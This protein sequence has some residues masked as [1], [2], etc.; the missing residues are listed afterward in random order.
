MNDMTYEMKIL[1]KEAS[2]AL[3]W[4]DMLW[5]D[6]ESVNVTIETREGKQTMKGFPHYDYQSSSDLYHE[7][8]R[9]KE[10]IDR[11]VNKTA[12]QIEEELKQFIGSEQWFPFQ[13]GLELTEGVKYVVDECNAA[14]FVDIIGKSQEKL[15]NEP[16]QWWTLTLNED[17]QGEV[18]C[19]D[20][21]GN[22]V[23]THLLDT[24]DFPLEKITL[25]KTQNVVMLPREN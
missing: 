16:F 12:A 24:V 18:T 13:H 23:A 15:E 20:G 25:Y 4:F 22:I 11:V 10:Q 6:V 8:M 17:R 21:D 2:E 5:K 7:A 9:R 1:L 14:W 3:G 19:D